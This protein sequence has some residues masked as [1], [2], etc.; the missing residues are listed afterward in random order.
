MKPAEIRAKS[1]EEILEELEG[2][3]RELLN[4]R[5][6]WQAGEMKNSSQYARTRKDVARMKTVLREMELG[7]N[8]KLYSDG[9]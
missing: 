6:Q 8:K 3:N 7:T 9:K 2:C 5:I 4:L 1:R